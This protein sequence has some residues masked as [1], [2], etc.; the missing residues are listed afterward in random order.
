V[1][2]SIV[3]KSCAGVAYL[4]SVGGSTEPTSSNESV[5]EELRLEKELMRNVARLTVQYFGHVV[6]GSAGE[7]SL[8]F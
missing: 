5:L 1:I 4:E 7:L 8:A 6:R 2:E 3:L